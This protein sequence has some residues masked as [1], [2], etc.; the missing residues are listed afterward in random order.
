MQATSNLVSS[1]VGFP[2]S[3]LAP[4]VLYG[5]LA[6]QA[7]GTVGAAGQATFTVTITGAS[8]SGSVA[9][10]SPTS[11]LTGPLSCYGY[12]SAANTV[13]IVVTN[14]SAAGVAGGTVTFN[15]VVMQ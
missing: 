12:V 11:T 8:T 9:I 7:I 6:S 15:V 4:S 14:G 5:Q 3:F 1:T 10:V 13:T 2:S